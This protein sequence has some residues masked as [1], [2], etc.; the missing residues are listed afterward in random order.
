MNIF[1]VVRHSHMISVSRV[2]TQYKLG[3]KYCLT[4]TPLHSF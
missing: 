1:I 3:A 4:I 2:N